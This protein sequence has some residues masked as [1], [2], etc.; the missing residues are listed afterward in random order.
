[1]I[2]S[3]SLESVPKT[4]VGFD[5]SEHDVSHFP[6]MDNTATV[7]NPRGGQ[8]PKAHLQLIKKVTDENWTSKALKASLASIKN[9]LHDSE[10][11][12]KVS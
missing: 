4:S 9:S 7:N 3:L 8:P 2:T 11:T 1:M 5:S 10:I 12:Q 6:Q